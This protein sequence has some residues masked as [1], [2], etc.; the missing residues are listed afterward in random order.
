MNIQEKASAAK[1]LRKDE[2]FQMFVAEVREAAIAEFVNSGPQDTDA[3]E[4]A[5]A[6]LRALAAIDGRLSAAEG[7]KA[8][9]DRKDQHRAND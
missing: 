7:A 1:R 3:R 9:N 4:E 8:I 6:I 5:H 2:A